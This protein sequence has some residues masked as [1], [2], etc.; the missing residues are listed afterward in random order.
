M[1]LFAVVYA[2]FGLLALSQTRHWRAV[3][4]SAALPPGQVRLLRVAG[5]ALITLSLM[6]ALTRDGPSFGIL[7]WVTV[8]S[9]AAL[10]V[11]FTLAGRARFASRRADRTDDSERSCY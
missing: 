6:I 1:A 9:M 5:A 8:L 4:G 2:G 7:L 10:A 3:A 11:A